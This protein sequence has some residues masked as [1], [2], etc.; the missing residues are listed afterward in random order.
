MLIVQWLA[1][2]WEDLTTNHKKLIELAFVHTG[3]LLAKDGSEDHKMSIQGWPAEPH[4]AYTFRR[5][6]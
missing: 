3:F 5:Y 6:V 2:A 1:D 4:P